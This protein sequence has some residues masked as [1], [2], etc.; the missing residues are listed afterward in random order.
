MENLIAHFPSALASLGGGLLIFGNPAFLAVRCS[1]DAGE[2]LIPDPNVRPALLIDPCKVP[3]NS[4]NPPVQSAI[5]RGFL[6]PQAYHREF[7]FRGYLW[8]SLKT[9]R[10]LKC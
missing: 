5:A 8:I 10:S 9:G 7:L 4:K 2:S 1:R 6:M 3:D